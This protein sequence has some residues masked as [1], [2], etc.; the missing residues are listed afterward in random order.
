MVVKYMRN[1][2]VNIGLFGG[3]VSDNS[4]VTVDEK[5]SIN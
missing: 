5:K 4:D 1:R 2:G 3:T